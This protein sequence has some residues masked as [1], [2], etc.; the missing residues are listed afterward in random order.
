MRGYVWAQFTKSA[1]C[2]VTEGV[3]TSV[4]PPARHSVIF[5][6]EKVFFLCCFV[7]AVVVVVLSAGSV[8]Q[9]RLI[10]PMLKGHRLLY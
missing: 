4:I 8:H 6:F 5:H 7:V 9:E 1:P 10:F 3:G 2:G